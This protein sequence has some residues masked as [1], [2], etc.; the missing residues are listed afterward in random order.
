[1]FFPSV[2]DCNRLGR[3]WMFFYKLQYCYVHVFD[4]LVVSIGKVFSNSEVLV[5]HFY[6]SV[7]ADES[8]LL[9]LFRLSYILFATCFACY[10][11][12]HI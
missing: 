11:L 5:R 8:I 6:S 2:P 7:V 4:S 10:G 12:D 9:S 3:L 1:M